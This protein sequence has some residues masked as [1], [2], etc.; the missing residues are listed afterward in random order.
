MGKHIGNERQRSDPPGD[1][2]RFLEQNPRT[3]VIVREQPDHP[4]V[5]QR[6]RDRELVPGDA[7]CREGVALVPLRRVEIVGEDRRLTQTEKPTRR[8]ARPRDAA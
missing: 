6:A 5:V 7:K 4:E 1:V 2:E 8:L 3:L